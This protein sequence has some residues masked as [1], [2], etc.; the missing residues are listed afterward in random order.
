[1]AIKGV[2]GQPKN[3]GRSSTQRN[4]RYPLLQELKLCSGRK[5]C[6]GIALLFRDLGKSTC[7]LS[8]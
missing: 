7:E 3:P 2:K 6:R 5:G 1:M 8:P 4:T